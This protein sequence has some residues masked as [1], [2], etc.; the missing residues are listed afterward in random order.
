MWGVCTASRPPQYLTLTIHYT[1]LWLLLILASFL[2]RYCSWSLSLASKWIIVRRRLAE[3]NRSPAK[4]SGGDC[5][6][7]LPSFCS[8]FSSCSFILCL[9][10]PFFFCTLRSCVSFFHMYSWFNFPF[11]PSL[12]SYF[13][14]FLPPF[15][16]YKSGLINRPRWCELRWVE[17]GK[18]SICYV[19]KMLSNI[20]LPVVTKYD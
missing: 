14:V 1:Q 17:S 10:L 13:S 6:F 9:S 3:R 11:L 15:T 7:L 2:F 5:L 16:L 8:L 18:V 19:M 20:C 12:S 4:R